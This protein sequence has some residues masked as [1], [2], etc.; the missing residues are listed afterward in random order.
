MQ[1]VIRSFDPASEFFTP[2]QCYI[3]ELSNSADDPAVS[4]ARA[5]VAPGVT[6]RWHRLAGTTERYVII[7][8]SGRVEVGNVAPQEVA[9]GDVVLI[10]PL[11]PQ[12]ITNTG[13]RDL[14]FLAV[15][16]PRFVQDAYEDIDDEPMPS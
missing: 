2:E 16:S 12:R 10:P 13:T 6:T 3:I 14:V 8:G 15:C 11:C 5:R 4:I 7:D 1:E 9:V